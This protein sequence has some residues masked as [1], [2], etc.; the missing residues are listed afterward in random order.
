MLLKYGIFLKA[1]KPGLCVTWK[2][3]SRGWNFFLSP[4]PTIGM[5]APNFFNFTLQ[6]SPTSK[7]NTVDSDLYNT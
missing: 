7:L 1:E 5:G 6:F 3:I 4:V 2:I